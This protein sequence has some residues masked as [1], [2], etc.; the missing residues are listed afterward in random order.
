MPSLNG[1][2]SKLDTFAYSLSRRIGISDR[3]LL[4][5]C[6]TTTLANLPYV[7]RNGQ[8]FCMLRQDQCGSLREC[9]PEFRLA[10]FQSLDGTRFRCYTVRKDGRTVAYAWLGSGDIPALHN[11]NGHEWTGLPIYLD[12]ETAYLFS[13]YVTSSSR[14]QR[15]YQVLASGIA[16]T[17]LGDGIRRIILTTDIRNSS[18]IK[19]VQRMGFELYGR[20]SFSAFSGWKRARYEVG[21]SFLPSKLGKYVGDC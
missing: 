20:T 1:L 4:F 13:V 21:A 7:L 10:D 18:S 5:G 9:N 16:S 12:Q 11:C 14:G 19:A 15:L 17:I 3:S 2:V 8:E 6:D